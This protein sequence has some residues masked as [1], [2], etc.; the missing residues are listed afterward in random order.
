MNTPDTIQLRDHLGGFDYKYTNQEF[1]KLNAIAYDS[2]RVINVFYH[3]LLNQSVKDR[4][5]NL[6][7][8]FDLDEQEKFH[9]KELRSFNG[10]CNKNFKNFLSCFIGSKS[11]SRQFLSSIL[12]KTKLW[13]ENTCTKNFKFDN[14]TLDGNVMSYV[15]GDEEKLLNKFFLDQTNYIGK[16]IINVSYSHCENL[17]N[18]YHLQDK[19]NSSFLNLVS[20]SMGVSY[21][22]YITEKFLNA[23]VTKTLFI[24]HGQPLWHWEIS[25]CY[26]FKIYDKIFDYRF[27]M[28]QNPV[29]RTVSLVEMILKF[30]DLTPHDWHD[31]YLLEK[32]TIEYNYDHYLSKSYLKNL[33]KFV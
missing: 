13:N 16:K 12:Y 15:N 20:E 18:L 26:G 28:I 30:K 19:I 10:N 2:H 7:F 21:V 33:V 29:R 6:K 23:V 17:S 1:E 31:L 4:Y 27:D 14:D 9:F 24:T 11:V 32:D 22:P 3:Q 25:E 5:K 8:Y